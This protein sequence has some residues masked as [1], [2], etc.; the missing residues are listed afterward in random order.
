MVYYTFNFFYLFR[1][2]CR[3]IEGVTILN[4]YRKLLRTEAK[5]ATLITVCAAVGG[6]LA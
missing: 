3:D 4:N 5:V 1:T 6:W 2:A